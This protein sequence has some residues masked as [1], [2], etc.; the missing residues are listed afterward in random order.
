MGRRASTPHRFGV[1]EMSL[2]GRVASTSAYEEGLDLNVGVR[3]WTCWAVLRIK[4]LQ[5]RILPS[6]PPPYRPSD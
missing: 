1:T 4:R 5:V 2:P 3:E 6:A